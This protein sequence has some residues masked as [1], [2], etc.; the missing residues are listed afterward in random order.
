MN[1]VLMDFED[2]IERAIRDHLNL[3]PEVDIPLEIPT[4]ERG[5]Y[6]LP[7]FFLSKTLKKPPERIASEIVDGI[8]LE[9][10]TSK[11]S[12]PYINFEIDDDYLVE[13]TIEG[14]MEAEESFGELDKREERVIIEHTSANPNAPLHVG[15]ARNP[16]IGDTIARIYEKA[17]YSVETQYYVDDMGKQVSLLASGLVHLDKED[18]KIKYQDDTFEWSPANIQK[19]DHEYGKIYR[20]ISNNYDNS[21]EI[22]GDVDQRVSEVE[23]DPKIHEEY[24]SK[25]M[26][27]IQDSLERLNVH[28]DEEKY[29]SDFV[30]NSEVRNVLAELEKLSVC[31]EEEGA[32]YINVDDQKVFLKRR[33]DT[34]LYPARDIAFHRWKADRADLMIDVLGEDHRLHTKSVKKALD[35]LGN[36]TPLRFVFYSFVTF[37]GEGMSTRGGKS[38]TLDEFMDKAVEKAEEEIKKRRED[39]TVDKL[40]DT[41]EKVGIG[42]IRFNIIKVQPPKHIDFHW[43]EALDFQGDSAPFIQYTHARASSILERWEGKESE[44]FERGCLKLDEEGEIKLVKEMARFPM[45]IKRSCEENAPHI[46]AKYALDLASEF[47]RF[48]RDYPVLKSEDKKIDRLRLVYSY[49]KT[50]ASLLD[51]LGISAPEYM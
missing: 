50:V 5:D 27:G 43:E 6:A 22:Q 38:I 23:R 48:Y 17:G 16:I 36:P 4:E 15:N 8:E 18:E 2:E 24:S 39:I 29:E 44:L 35:E 21:L 37:E 41:A 45:M 26:E 34:S 32:L 46:L 31:G 10:G 33:D 13:K 42:A 47:N 11:A 30:E 25:V 1:Y 28:I 20:I 12:G 49:K 7:C 14:C 9:H 3:D 19:I 40:K 51:T